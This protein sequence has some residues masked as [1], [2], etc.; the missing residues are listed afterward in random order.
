MRKSFLFIGLLIG[1]T[2]PAYALEM[3]YVTFN[4]I[5]QMENAFRYI[6][7]F[8]SNDD[9]GSL[10]YIAAVVGLAAG[11]VRS[12]M[13]D[14]RE[15]RTLRNWFFM[16]LL[17]AGIYLAFIVPKGTIHIY[18]RTLN[19][20]EPVAGVP[21][22]ILLVAGLTNLAE[23]VAVDI[24]NTSSPVPYENTAG[25][26]VFELVRNT[27]RSTQPFDDEYLWGKYKETPIMDKN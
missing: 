25:G 8:F 17:G 26:I 1:L 27:F 12:T 7:L 2:A 21:D 13:N 20:Y 14:Y 22:G 3:E 16:F 24:A 18:D 4:G 5:D 10:V 11:A 19:A 9:Y 6:A 15:E 23:Q